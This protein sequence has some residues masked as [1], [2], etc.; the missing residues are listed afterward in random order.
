MEEKVIQLCK[1]IKIPII[2]ISFYVD[3]LLFILGFKDKDKS[4]TCVARKY[5]FKK[6]N[7]R[8]LYLIISQS[9]KK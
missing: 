7:L 8:F 5:R 3:T 1:M 6:K 9:H 4:F 2:K